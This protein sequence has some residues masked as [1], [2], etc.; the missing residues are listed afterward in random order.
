[1]CIRDRLFRIQGLV[2]QFISRVEVSAKWIARTPPKRQVEGSNPSEPVSIL[3][4][5]KPSF[6]ILVVEMSVLE[7][8]LDYDPMQ[9]FSYALKAAESRRQYPR[10]FSRRLPYLKIFQASSR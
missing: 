7:K 6:I 3:S 9:V 1:M 10:K 8:E 4:L 5:Y 2:A